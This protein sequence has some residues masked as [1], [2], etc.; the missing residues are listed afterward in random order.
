MWDIALHAG[1]FAELFRSQ[2]AKQFFG[3]GEGQAGMPGQLIQREGT[4]DIEYL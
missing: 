3:N 2:A 1:D 4:G